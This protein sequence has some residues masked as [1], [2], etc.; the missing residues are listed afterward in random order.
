MT[1]SP[2][3]TRYNGANWKTTLIL[4]PS[5]GIGLWV[6]DFSAKTFFFLH[7]ILCPG[8]SGPKIVRKKLPVSCVSLR[9]CRE[10]RQTWEEW[11]CWQALKTAPPKTKLFSSAE[12]EP[13]TPKSCELTAALLIARVTDLC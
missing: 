7:E 8:L 10:V 1:I 11:G 9:I 5:W 6:P 3:A 13:L 4:G 12:L 2:M